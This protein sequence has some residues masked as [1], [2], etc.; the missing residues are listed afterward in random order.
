MPAC[1]QE[2]LWMNSLLC[3]MRQQMSDLQTAMVGGPLAMPFRLLP[4]VFSLQ[5]E[6]VPVS[7]THPNTQPCT[8]S[9]T[10]WLD[11]PNTQPC[12]HS[13]TSWLDDLV[14]RHKQLHGWV[15]RRMVPTFDSTGRLMEQSIGRG[16]LTSVWLGG[17][18]NPQAL[19]T[20]LQQEK[21]VLVNKNADQIVLKSVVLNSQDVSD[22]EVEEG[23]LFV[24]DIYLQGADWNYQQDTLDQAKC[25]LFHIPCLYICPVVKPNP[26]QRSPED[27]DDGTD[28]DDAATAASPQQPPPP[29]ETADKENKDT[30]EAGKTETGEEAEETVGSPHGEKKKEGT[31]LS[32]K[33][34]S[35]KSASVA[36]ERSGREEISP[37]VFD[38]PVYMNKS[39]QILVSMLPVNCSNPVE[40]WTL[41]SAAFVLDQGLP[42]GASKKSR[43]YLLLQRLPTTLRGEE[44]EEDMG[45][46][47]GE[48]EEEDD[49]EIPQAET[50]SQISGRTQ[51]SQLSYKPMTP[52]A[53]PLPVGMGLTREPAMIK[54]S[55]DQVVGGAV[56]PPL[57]SSRPA[58]AQQQGSRPAS[59][60]RAPRPPSGARPGSTTSQ[61][62]RRPESQMSMHSR[63]K[64]SE[65][66]QAPVPEDTEQTQARDEAAEGTEEGGEQK[67][68]PTP[69]GDEPEI[70]QLNRQGEMQRGSD[71]VLADSKENRVEE[72]EKDEMEESDKTGKPAATHPSADAGAGLQSREH[73][74]HPGALP[75]RGPS[76]SSRKNQLPEESQ[77]ETTRSSEDVQVVPPVRE[78]EAGR[79][80]QAEAESGPKP[81]AEERSTD[82]SERAEDSLHVEADMKAS[83]NN[84]ARDDPDLAPVEKSGSK[85][86]SRQSV[87]SVGAS[88]VSKG[89]K[90]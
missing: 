64:E 67:E 65:T 43:S 38:C 83:G 68:K 48:E 80:G 53:S 79:G 7:W 11:D 74:S 31:V 55:Q 50:G 56:E 77:Q 18:V 35:Q 52:K 29:A 61:G 40:K 86:P 6:L 27:R 22:F 5:E 34:S 9:L 36:G 69:R 20:S 2:C 3:Y 47:E 16:R 28:E 88:S 13:L 42:E 12:T 10:S 44:E 24:N 63:G 45:E 26:E 58:S 75:P 23:G 60:S 41:A 57:V 70:E 21:A 84:T 32:P 59:A 15:K 19:L 39:R 89:K 81:A 51:Q 54:G 90:K 82:V 73:T 4:I 66:G 33:A 46:E 14:K 71:Q 8:H 17:L 78:D 85:P 49:V 62:A 25:S 76:A 30:A 72:K 87:K 37:G 1:L